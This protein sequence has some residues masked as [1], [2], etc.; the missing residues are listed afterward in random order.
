MA[1]FA[2]D[3]AGNPPAKFVHRHIEMDGDQIHIAG[4]GTKEFI[5]GTG[6]CQSPGKAI[7]HPAGFFATSATHSRAAT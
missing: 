4:E 5:Q 6:L 1:F 3:P 2:L 7:K